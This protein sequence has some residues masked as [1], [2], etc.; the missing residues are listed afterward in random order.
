MRVSD[1]YLVSAILVVLN[2]GLFVL[3]VFLYSPAALCGHLF[4]VRD[5]ERDKAVFVYFPPSTDE[6]LM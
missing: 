3:F 4:C 5:A 2:D 6:A 1:V